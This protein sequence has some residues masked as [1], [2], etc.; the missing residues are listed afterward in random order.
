MVAERVSSVMAK[1]GFLVLIGFDHFLY[2]SEQR[3]LVL[4]HHGFQFL[5]ASFEHRQMNKQRATSFTGAVEIF[6][7]DVLA[8][9]GTIGANLQPQGMLDLIQISGLA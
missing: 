5:G 1:N 9:E 7:L 8:A 2:P 3:V 6:P 4:S